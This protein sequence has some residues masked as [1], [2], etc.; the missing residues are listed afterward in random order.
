MAKTD[1]EWEQSYFIE[2][3]NP[4]KDYWLTDMDKTKQ[5]KVTIPNDLRF[6]ELILDNAR[7]AAQLLG[8]E[9][10]T[11][12]EIQLGTEEVLSSIIHNAF[13]AEQNASI[14]VIF[15]LKP[16]GLEIVIREKGL[17]FDPDLCQKFSPE[18]FKKDKLSKGL[19]TYLA[20]GLMDEF[21]FHNLGR[22]GKETYLFKYLDQKRIDNILTR[23]ELNHAQAQDKVES[24]PPKSVN[25]FVRLL[26]EQ[27]A[28]EVAKCVYSAYGYT[29]LHEDMYYP[30]RVRTLNKSGDLLSFVA[31]KDDDNE[32]IAHAALIM[33]EDPLVPECGVAATKPK[34]RGQG[35][36][37]RL[38]Q[39]RIDEARKRGFMGVYGLGVTTHYFSQKSMLKHDLKPCA[40]LLSNAREPLYKNITEK[41]IQRES[42][43]LQFKYL[44]A[45][46]KTVIYP[47][48][49]HA[50]FIHQI[51]LNLGISP[52]MGKVGEHQELDEHES[53]ISLKTDS[54]R[55]TA[56]LRV[57]KYGRNIINQIKTKCEALAPHS[58]KTIYLH[59]PLMDKNT[60]KYCSYLEKLGFFFAG[61]K[62]GSNNGDS[63]ILQHLN[64]HCINYNLL[65]T[66][67]EF[68]AAIKEYVQDQDLK[69]KSI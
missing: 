59:L 69:S 45:P 53:S 8:F 11:I 10:K 60:A 43:V 9:D 4:Q 24:L 15:N 34:Y 67:C 36:L 46:E 33:G 54:E 37:N 20:K 32:V 7:N 65:A 52:E 57:H 6:L 30:Q 12:Y 61:I 58:V 62:P 13:E 26:K 44:N 25:Y 14:D 66:G 41:D 18:K 48:E 5:V 19:G 42:A 16:S 21:S 56:D 39:A 47:P 55:V 1:T 2:T 64:E 22:K 50:D 17:P 40:L 38:S 27:E 29:Y 63:L 49:N 23:P 51:Y 35:C 3:Q 28:I 31:V 68:S